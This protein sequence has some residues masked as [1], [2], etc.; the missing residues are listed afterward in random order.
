VFKTRIQR[1]PDS[2]YDGIVFVY[3]ITNRE[4][5]ES[6]RGY[7]EEL[8]SDFQQQVQVSQRRNSG[9][10]TNTDTD[11]NSNSNTNSDSNSAA[12]SRF[13]KFPIV[14]I[15]NKVDLTSERAVSTEEGAALARE[16]G[17]GFVEVSATQ[18]N[19]NIENAFL[20]LIRARRVLDEEE[21]ATK[22]LFYFKIKSLPF[23]NK[24]NNKSGTVKKPLRDTVVEKSLTFHRRCGK[25]ASLLPELAKDLAGEIRE[26]I[27]DKK[28]A[29]IT[30]W[31]VIKEVGELI[32]GLAQF[33]LLVLFWLG[34]WV[35]RVQITCVRQS[36]GGMDGCE[37][38]PD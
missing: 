13:E 24:K 18:G 5:F 20:N 1:E 2:R 31:G 32:K 37:L 12:W 15:G 26:Y 10:D 21:R 23:N 3:D 7:Y 8:R 11:T 17:C 29:G 30:P 35:F 28:K 38:H 6:V 34:I 33:A 36:K 16:L 14:I 9:I 19:G 27:R 4:S 25:V 22:P